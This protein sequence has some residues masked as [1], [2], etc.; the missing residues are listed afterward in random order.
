M[1]TQL[2]KRLSHLKTPAEPQDLKAR[3]L[4]TI[5]VAPSSQKLERKTARPLV[6]RR[7]AIAGGLMFSALAVAAFW[8]T[9]PSNDG[10]TF[11]S[12][13][14]AFA[15]TMEEFGKVA[16]GHVK[17]RDME[18]GILQTGWRESDFF[19]T[20]M[21]FDERKGLYRKR[22]P[23]ASNSQV[24][25]AKGTSAQA[26][27]LPDG[28]CY[29]RY[30][31]SPN[32]LVTSSPHHWNAMKKTFTNLLAGRIENPVLASTASQ[33]KGQKAQLFQSKSVLSEAPANSRYRTDLYVNPQTKLPIA[34]QSF[35]TE[36]NAPSHLVTEYEFDY[37]RPDAAYFDPTSLKKGA[38]IHRGIE[39]ETD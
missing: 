8:N 39:I 29:Y 14:V 20:E 3:C 7:V 11:S 34:L 12:S 2:E 13:S 21:W 38:V 25:L 36:R 5:P 35:I 18:A 28:T 10:I 4:S 16:F 30:A 15:Q 9:R 27:F 33:W 24:A 17:G 19:R 6:P 26:L 23:G 32:L 1:Q 22:Q 31:N 37:T